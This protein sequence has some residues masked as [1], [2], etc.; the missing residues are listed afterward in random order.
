MEFTAWLPELWEDMLL[1]GRLYDR[2]DAFPP[3]KDCHAAD[4]RRGCD[5][6]VDE[7]TIV[8]MFCADA[9]TLAERLPNAP[10]NERAADVPLDVVIPEYA[11]DEGDTV[12][13]EESERSDAP[14][15]LKI[16]VGLL[17]L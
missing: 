10:L 1:I 9:L 11:A 2:K 14:F 7:A 16:L 4:G 6:A 17:E 5:V 12:I 3:P 13:F 8:G 15:E